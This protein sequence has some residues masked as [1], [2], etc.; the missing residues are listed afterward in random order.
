MGEIYFD[1]PAGAQKKKK[2][3]TSSRSKTSDRLKQVI[4][5][6]ACFSAITLPHSHRNDKETYTDSEELILILKATL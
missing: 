5:G 2:K 3:K 4:W 1:V 6:S